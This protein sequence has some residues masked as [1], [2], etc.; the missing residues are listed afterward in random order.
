MAPSDRVEQLADEAHRID[1]IVVIARRKPQ[2]PAAGSGS[3][4]YRPSALIISPPRLP[5]CVLQ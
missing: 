5:T 1:Q 2:Q 3:A 4:G